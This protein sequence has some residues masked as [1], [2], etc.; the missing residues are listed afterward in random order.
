MERDGGCVE[1]QIIQGTVQGSH[2]HSGSNTIW[3]KSIHQW[4]GLGLED[5][6]LRAVDEQ[7]LLI[8]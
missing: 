2:K 8:V 3:M 7:G 6:S 1:E 4:F 5:P